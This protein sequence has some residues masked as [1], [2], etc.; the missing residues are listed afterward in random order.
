[1]DARATWDLEPG[2]GFL[3]VEMGEAE[4]PRANPAGDAH[5]VAEDG[6]RGKVAKAPAQH[7]R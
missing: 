7:G 3:A 4:Q 1:M 2:S 6:G 5:V